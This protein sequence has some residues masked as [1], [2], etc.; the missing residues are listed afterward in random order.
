MHSVPNMMKVTSNTAEQSS[1]PPPITCMPPDK[2]LL[3]ETPGF[4][5]CVDTKLFRFLSFSTKAINL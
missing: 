1:P 4:C 2:F 3:P 5:K